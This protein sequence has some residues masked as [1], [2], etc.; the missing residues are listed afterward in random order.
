M[1]LDAHQRS[2]S[3]GKRRLLIALGLTLVM[4]VIEFVAGWLSGS[5]SLLADA[6]HMLTDSSTLALSVF[7]AWL[8][9]K[10]ANSQK[11]YGYY[12]TEI[13][14]A[15]ANGVA[16]CLIVVWIYARALQRLRSPS[17]VLSG[18]MIT[19]AAVGLAVN[20]LSG[21][22]LKHDRS[23]NLNIHGAWLNVMSDALGS[24]GV[25]LAGLLIRWRGWTAA[26]P[27]A[28]MMI[29]ILIA[30]NSWNLLTQSVNILLEGTPR[31]L[32]M[33]DVMQAMQTVPG[34][35]DVHDIHLWTI[36]T[37]MDAMSGHVIIEDVGRSAEILSV[38]NRLLSERFGI[39]HTTLQLEPRTHICQ[40]ASVP[41]KR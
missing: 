41:E 21:W 36:T 8:A 7:A 25:I 15:L 6:G 5:L 35:R 3:G 2:V 17:T 38:L 30:L 33:P 22:I 16:L 31:H 23:S 27:I 34:V 26:D 18:P 10:P 4:M 13:L 11:T 14:A 9:T 39:T 29:G 37:G 1:S 24:V 12:R 40:M 19:V 32:Q 20:L 28:S